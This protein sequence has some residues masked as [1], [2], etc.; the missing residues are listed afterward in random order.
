MGSKP[1]RIYPDLLTFLRY[2]GKTQ[3]EVADAVGVSQAA[4]SRYLLNGTSR[5]AHRD[6]RLSIALKLAEFCHIPVESLATMP[7]L[8]KPS[9]KRG[10]KRGRRAAL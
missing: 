6:M 10:R 1:F 3:M 7:P 9:R 2:S 8:E 4:L 5:T